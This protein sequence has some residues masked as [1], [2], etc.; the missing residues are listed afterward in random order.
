MTLTGCVA[1]AVSQALRALSTLR[2]VV[3]LDVLRPILVC[4]LEV[5]AGEG[6]GANGDA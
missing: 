1:I 3:R 4:M 6:L 5:S 2:L